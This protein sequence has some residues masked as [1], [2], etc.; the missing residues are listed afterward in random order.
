MPLNAGQDAAEKMHFLLLK[1]G[2]V[3]D[4]AQTTKD[5]FLMLGRMEKLHLFKDRLKVAIKRL[6]DLAGREAL[7]GGSLLNRKIGQRAHEKFVGNHLQG[8]RHIQ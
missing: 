6:H 4:P 8:S 1:G 7:R 2:P 3:E 5:G